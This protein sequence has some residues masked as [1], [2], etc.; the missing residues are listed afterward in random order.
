M[1]D[2]GIMIVV[3]AIILLSG[4]SQIFY[5]PVHFFQ[6]LGL[7]TWLLFAFL[8]LLLFGLFSASQKV[9]TKYLSAGWAYICFIAA[10]ILVSVFFIAF[11]LVDFNFSQKTFWVGSMA[12]MFDGLGVLAIYA[13]YSSNG[14]A[15]Q[16][17]S[18][19]TSIQQVFTICLAIIFLKETL[20]LAQFT[21]I[22]LAIVGAWFILLEKKKGSY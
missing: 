9:T 21:G 2:T 10:S 13:A 6:S 12:G 16:V 22:G 15:S 5:D 17:S 14:K 3:P 7:R 19:V 18:I 4:Q 11:G 1:N 8:A 20:A